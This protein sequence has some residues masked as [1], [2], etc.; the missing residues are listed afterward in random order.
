[1]DQGSTYTASFNLNYSLLA[2]SPNT[3]IVGVKD[4]HEFFG[5]NHSV[6]KQVLGDVRHLCMEHR[7]FLWS[8]GTQN[9]AEVV[10]IHKTK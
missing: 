2:L 3:V 1:M 7:I 9:L 4:L 10:A 6:H 8:Q 5:G